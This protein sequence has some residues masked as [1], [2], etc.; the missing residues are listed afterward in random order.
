MSSICV[1]PFFLGVY[2]V[3]VLVLV[4]WGYLKTRH[5]EFSTVLTWEGTGIL[6]ALLLLSVFTIGVFLVYTMLDIGF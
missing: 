1:V 2:V 6:L 3:I 4:A 5:S